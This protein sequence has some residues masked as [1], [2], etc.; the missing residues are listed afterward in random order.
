MILVLVGAK[1]ALEVGKLGVFRVERRICDGR[2][3]MYDVRFETS[4]IANHKSQIADR[5]SEI[6]FPS[7]PLFSS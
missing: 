5:Q 2:F 4:T 6:S 7:F 1:D 3:A